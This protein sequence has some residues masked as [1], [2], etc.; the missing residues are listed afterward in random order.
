MMKIFF[1]LL[2]ITTLP[3]IVTAQTV[4]KMKSEGGVSIIPCKVNGL[5][6]NFIFDT[7]ASEVSISL[8]E[9][10]FMLK[11]GYLDTSD[12]IGTSN[13]LDASGNINEGVVINLKEVEIAGLKLSN[14]RATIIKNMKAP[15]LLGQTAISKLGNIQ[16]DLSSN[17]LT[18]LKGKQTFDYSIYSQDS[19]QSG[20][21]STDIIQE[22]KS[23]SEYFERGRSKARKDY[24][25]DAIDDF[26]KAIEINP[27]YEEAYYHRAISKGLMGNYSGAI[28]DYDKVIEI[29]PKNFEAYCFRGIDKANSKNYKGGL[30]DLNKSIF[31]NP[32]NAVAYS[33]RGEVKDKIKDYP[34]G[35]MDYTKAIQLNSK[36]PDYFLYRGYSKGE[37]KDYVGALADYNKAIQ[38]GSEDYTAYLNRANMKVK[39]KYFKNALADYDKSIEINPESA[40][41]Y[42]ARGLAK[43]KLKDYEGAINDYDKTL[44]IDSTF[45]MASI[46]KAF[47][48][49]TI[50]ENDW[51]NVLSQNEQ[52]WFIKSTF[53]SRDGGII[54]IWIKENLQKKS[55]IKNGK[56]IN[57]VNAKMMMLAEFDC[58][59]KMSK[60]NSTV[61]YDSKGNV[62]QR[63]T[64]ETNWEDITP[65]TIQ[66]L[67][68]TKVCERFN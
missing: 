54:K 10:T 41:T 28:K 43:D 36:N 51:I 52:Q 42:Y 50:K 18:I 22:P 60:F 16:I 45:Y 34:G 1:L 8:T 7:G 65:E 37:L 23:A 9:A 32:K 14:V 67:L 2:A 5:S 39:L 11:N 26:T 27:N 61:Y 17:T 15:L 56:T 35:I 47:A 46:M 12:I 44:Q 19:T 55:L 68:F 21:T 57:Y 29:N 53:V 59:N 31:L 66:E 13:Y 4:I 25:E 38:L 40:T 3:V 48:E 49:K 64:N 6:L 58:I 24:Y 33:C 62:L 63:S 20:E 30:S